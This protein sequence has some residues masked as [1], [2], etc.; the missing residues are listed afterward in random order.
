MACVVRELWEYWFQQEREEPVVDLCRAGGG[1]I[2]L[3]NR[4]RTMVRSAII[5]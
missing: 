3:R 5:N 1:R 4:F 2:L